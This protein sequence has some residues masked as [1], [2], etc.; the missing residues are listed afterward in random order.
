MHSVCGDNNKVLRGGVPILDEF[1]ASSGLHRSGG[2]GVKIGCSPGQ[3]ES[4]LVPLR[5]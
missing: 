3:L 4:T 1:P 5:K 2:V